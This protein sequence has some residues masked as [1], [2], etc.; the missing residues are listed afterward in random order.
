MRLAATIFLLAAAAGCV[1]TSVQHTKQPMIPRSDLFRADIWL[2]FSPP[3][4]PR[5][6]VGGDS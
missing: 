2:P 4:T 6:A 5:S 1:R 3:N